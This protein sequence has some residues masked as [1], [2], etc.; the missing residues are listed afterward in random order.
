MRW[1]S[2]T[3][4]SGGP[5][6][7]GVVTPDE[8]SGRVLDVGGWARSRGADSPADLVDLVE[9]SPANQE[10]VADL[11]RSAP[12]DGVG[13]VR[14]E[15]VR[16]LAPLRAPATLRQVSA[17]SSAL[18]VFSHVPRR[19]VLGP[20]DDMAVPTYTDKLD[21]AGHV[22]AVVGRKGRDLEAEDAVATVF[23]WT[24]MLHWSARDAA[25][26]V[27]SALGPWVV[28]PDEWRP[29]GTHEVTLRVDGELW[30]AGATNDR[31]WT[32]GQVLS[33]V[34][35]GED[36][37]AGDVVGLGPLV[38][39]RDDDRWLRVGQDVQVSVAG[40]GELHLRTG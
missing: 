36:L 2:F 7:L 21:V 25:R 13:W 30:Q 38:T 15:E 19:G 33:W 5:A 24:V 35:R 14:R 6:R 1:C 10:R 9:S 12:A 32:A 11:V 17:R 28:T 26:D 18:P 22:A 4:A 16:F 29:S 8:G 20:D 3:T 39:A 23:G 34:S 31:P 37:A 40:L 27:V